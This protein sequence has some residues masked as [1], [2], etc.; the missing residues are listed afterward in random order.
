MSTPNIRSSASPR[1]FALAIWKAGVN[2]VKAEPLIDEHVE[3][4]ENDLVFGNRSLPLSDVGRICVVGAGKAAGFLAQALETKLSGIAAAHPIDGWIN[5]PA[6][7]VEPTRFV[8]LH[9]ARP[10]GVN[11]PRPEGVVG[12]EKIRALVS[13][14]KPDDLCVCL[15]T[16]G[17]SALLP[18]PA[19]GISLADKLQVTR[20][21][22]AAGADIRELN[23]VRIS[24]SS[25]KG[26][27]LARACGASRMITL[28]ISD[29]IGDPLDLIASG[30][31]VNMSPS[32]AE[33]LAILKRYA[34]GARDSI[35]DAVWRDLEDRAGQ[36]ATAA[37]LHCEVENQLLANNATA[38]EAAAREARRQ[39]F[40]TEILPPE[41]AATS[42][43]EVGRTLAEIMAAR[44]NK[45]PVCVIWG[46]EPV[47]RLAPATR[48]GKG[49][50]NQQLVLAALRHWQNDLNEVIP[51]Q[52]CLLSGGTDGEDGPTDAAGAFFDATVARQAHQQRLQT[53]QYL[54]RNDA[55]TF[56]HKTGGLIKTGPTR[57]NV[58]DLRV[59]VFR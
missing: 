11:E 30:P 55:Y 15:L 10:S 56:F 38:A 44:Q 21:L 36:V 23:R 12:S 25:L 27:G 16:G 40:A 32:P 17:G 45:S 22:S 7:C 52:L 43:E 34:S 6:N 37:T 28:I 24:L 1:E 13:A 3:L 2:A 39:H 53:D 42:A 41:S 33:A 46:G 54:S 47:V 49:G 59:A 9:A 4:K 48:R 20:F 8:H 35:P 50:R 19:R 51:D 31:T 58:C 14:L 18:A 57:T 5:V 29:V 26:G